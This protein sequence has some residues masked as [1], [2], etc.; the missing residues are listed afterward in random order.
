[1]PTVLEDVRA[2]ILN[3]KMSERS[4]PPPFSNFI[5]AATGKLTRKEQ[6]LSLSRLVDRANDERL[7]HGSGISQVLLTVDLDMRRTLANQGLSLRSVP[8]AGTTVTLKTVV[9]ENSG[10]DNTTATS[11]LCRSIIE[12]GAKAVRALRV[13]FA[14]IDIVTRDPGVPLAES[15]GVI[16]EVNG[17]PNLYYHYQK[18]DGRF[19]V[20]VHL[21]RRLLNLDP[22]MA[23]EIRSPVETE[24]AGALRS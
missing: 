15:G 16:L 18:H 1:M 4:G 19:P 9:N 24:P 2:Q 20:A 11:Q 6:V 21:L 7:K 22:E 8:S 10:A 23:G 17:T 14:G 12:D 3:S 13:R 5:G